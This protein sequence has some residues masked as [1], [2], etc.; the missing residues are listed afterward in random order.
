MN[1]INNI[2]ILVTILVIMV[3]FIFFRIRD[4]F[5]TDLYEVQE[6]I[7]IVYT[8]VDGDDKEWLS[9]KNLYKNGTTK[10]ASTSNRFKNRDEIKY[11]IR[12]LVMF[13]PWIRNIYIV[14]YSK[15][16]Y[17]SWL[18][19]TND[20]INIISHDDIFPDK[21]HLPTFNSQAIEC[22]L[23]NISGPIRA[24]PIFK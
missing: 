14:T 23:C 21:S 9:Q 12:S 3:S 1:G 11:S 19:I 5:N 24:F 16:S 4:N 15:S 2:L 17:P 20:K 18:D 22:H 13:A 8:W 6:P 7:D 10:D